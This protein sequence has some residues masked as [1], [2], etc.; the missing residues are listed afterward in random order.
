MHVNPPLPVQRSAVQ[1][2]AAHMIISTAVLLRC[3]LV[4]AGK[5][6][7]DGRLLCLVSCQPALYLLHITLDRPAGTLELSHFHLVPRYAGHSTVMNR[8]IDTWQ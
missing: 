8:G 4:V 7:G 1:R 6:A 3:V 2:G 5:G